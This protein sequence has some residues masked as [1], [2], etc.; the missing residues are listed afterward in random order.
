M[1]AFVKKI[2]W[3]KISVSIRYVFQQYVTPTYLSSKYPY[4]GL[5]IS[6]SRN[7]KVLVLQKEKLSFSQ[8]FIEISGFLEQIGITDPRRKVI[9]QLI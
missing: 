2:H 6:S 3:F 9:Y 8:I 7:L 1:F 5:I 4:K